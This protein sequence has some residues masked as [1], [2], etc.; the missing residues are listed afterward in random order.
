MK[1]AITAMILSCFCLAACDD[2]KK[3]TEAPP[4]TPAINWSPERKLTWDDFKRKPKS[5]T[6]LDAESAVYIS[7]SGVACKDGKVVYDV[8]AEFEPDESWVDP[9]KKSAEILTHEQGH[10]DLAELY[11]RKLR[12]ALAA[13][14]PLCE[15]K[16][17]FGEA[18]QK[19][20]KQNQD[21]FAKAQE[22]YDTDT[23]HGE[24]TDKQKQASADIQKD[25][26]ELKDYKS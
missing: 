19:A 16:K 14:A 10:F 12:K 2:T 24:D 25:L 4:K 8:R 23:D 20:I 9:N 11:A 6:G 5:G 26:D 21:D 3:P 7:T 22:K 1:L 15:D 13:L 18:A 17:K